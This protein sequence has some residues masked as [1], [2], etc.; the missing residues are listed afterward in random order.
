[1]K[2]PI[3]SVLAALRSAAP[4][5]SD[6]QVAESFGVPVDTYRTWCSA[7]RNVSV[8]IDL[9]RTW[10]LD[11]F[12]RQTISMPVCC[13]IA[14][15]YGSIGGH[16]PGCVRTGRCDAIRISLGAL[17]HAWMPRGGSSTS[18][19]GTA[20]AMADL[21]GYALL[22]R[23]D[24]GSGDQDPRV[25]GSSLSAWVDSLW[26]TPYLDTRSFGLKEDDVLE[27][28]EDQ[29]APHHREAA[30]WDPD[31]DPHSGSPR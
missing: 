16:V 15:V 31:G 7:R 21:L 24:L 22:F 28:L 12:G 14:D 17:P 27:L 13:R 26:S 20:V 25:P 5:Q 8:D 9:Y 23:T 18:P 30:P 1:M 10:R 19:G 6:H 2:T 29:A 3:H 11:A 4:H